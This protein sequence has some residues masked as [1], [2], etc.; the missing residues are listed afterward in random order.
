MEAKPGSL[1]IRL[2]PLSARSHPLTRLDLIH[3][4]LDLIYNRLGLIHTRLDLIHLIQYKQ[5][6]FTR[7]WKISSSP[8]G[9]VV[10]F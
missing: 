3:T 6:Y 2:D 1:T 7:W 5:K 8:L 9:D 10:T 4:R